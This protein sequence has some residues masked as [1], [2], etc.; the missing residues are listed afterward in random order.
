MWGTFVCP[1]PSTCLDLWTEQWGQCEITPQVQNHMW[2]LFT[3]YSG[4]VKVIPE[5]AILE[6]LT[7]K[8]SINETKEDR[9]KN[10]NTNKELN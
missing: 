3:V 10:H 6:Q 2:R 9:K 7:E 1:F 8:L 5:E 4:E